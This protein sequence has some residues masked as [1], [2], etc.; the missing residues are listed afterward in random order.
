[1]VRRGLALVLA[2][3]PDLEVVGA[4]GT[5]AEL[6]A[7]PSD[8]AVVDRSLGGVDALA[9]R[10]GVVVLVGEAAPSHAR[11][12]FRLGARG[13]VTK[14]A[15]DA[16]LKSAVRAVAAGQ[17]YLS[18]A[19]GA[20]IA[21]TPEDA[22]SLRETEVLRLIGLGHT[23]GEIAEALVLSTRTVEA[24]RARLLDKLGVTTRAGLVRAALDRGLR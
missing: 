13:V 6:Q 24:H 15:E 12:A 10:A 9:G 21:G 17:T 8:V 22:L 19:V 3:E 23:N 2:E 18:P 5:V 7:W 16:E 1:M 14:S 20:R 11:E 4:A